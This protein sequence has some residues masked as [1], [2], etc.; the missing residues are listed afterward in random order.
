MHRSI[1]K[2]PLVLLAL[3]VSGCLA[4][5]RLATAAALPDAD[6][7]VF[8]LGVVPRDFKISIRSG[9]VRNGVF[10]GSN[11]SPAVFVG[12]PENGLIVGRS[13]ASASLGITNITVGSPL[14][15]SLGGGTHYGPCDGS[16]TLVFRAQPGKVIYIG[17]IRYDL[18]SRR[19][20]IAYS[21][22]LDRARRNLAIRYPA[23][24]ER[25]EAGTYELLPTNDP[26]TTTTFIFLPG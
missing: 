13:R 16:K 11:L 3:S 2:L 18:L 23:L 6:Q 21:F 25:L 5:G 7:S 9:T 1:R 20:S 10:A 17:D 12:R 26:C 24:A 15:L 19:M 14:Q 8:V 4:H 22:D